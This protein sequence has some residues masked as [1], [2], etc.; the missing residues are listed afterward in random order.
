[1][2]EGKVDRL[3]MLQVLARIDPHPESVP[4]NAL[5]RVEGTPLQNAEPVSALEMVRMVATARLLMPRAMVR[6]SAGRSEMSLEA[7]ALCF[8]AG[9]NSIFSGDRL[10]TTPNPGEDQDRALLRD[11]GM[12]ALS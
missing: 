2:G 1:M 11:L 4:I 10:L 8:T 5:A 6:L 9:A 3:R 7:Q 12:E